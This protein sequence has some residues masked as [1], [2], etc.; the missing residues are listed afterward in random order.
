MGSTEVSGTS[1]RPFL[2]LFLLFFAISPLFAQNE[3]PKSNPPGAVSLA[4]ELNRLETLASGAVAGTGAQDRYNAF[5]AL[6]RLHQLSGNHEFALKALDGALAISPDDGRALFEYARFHIS[7]GEYEKAGMALS[8]LLGK[9]REKELFIQG[10]CLAAQL[11]VFRGNTGALVA[12]VQDPEF[13]G[14]LSGIYYTLWKL[15]GLASYRTSLTSEFPQSPEAKIAAGSVD[16]AP[17]PLWLLF[18]GRD[19]IALANLTPA[20]QAHSPAPVVSQPAQAPVSPF[21]LQTGLFSREENALALAERLKKTGFEPQINKRQVNGNDRWA[22]YVPGGM[23]M[24][25]E[26][27]KL[28]DAGFESFP[29]PNF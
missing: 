8:A 26:I 18:P 5:L 6:A 9:D 27:K 14:Y 3:A 19:S 2:F 16:F 20:P 22:V 24:N 4:A 23:D 7:M 21:V 1:Q 12:L 29:A 11:E 17:T 10:Q 15:T 13:A 28:K 25:A